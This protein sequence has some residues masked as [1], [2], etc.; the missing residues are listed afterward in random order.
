LLNKTIKKNHSCLSLYI[1][2]H[3]HYL[4]AIA[5]SR[6]LLSL[7]RLCASASLGGLIVDHVWVLEIVVLGNVNVDF[8]IVLIIVLILGLP[9]INHQTSNKI[10]GIRIE[11][12]IAKL[13]A[14]SAW[15]D[16]LLFPLG[17]VVGT[18]ET[19]TTGTEDEDGLELGLGDGLGDGE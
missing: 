12:E 1:D 5:W 8:V 4:T 16:R 7:S 11:K 19:V 9:F 17:S 15:F 2:S 18:A 14:I 10:D 6:L 13:E 3:Q